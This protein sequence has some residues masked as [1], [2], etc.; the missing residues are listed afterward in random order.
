MKSDNRRKVQKPKDNCHNMITLGAKNHCAVE[1][2]S[3]NSNL[4]G[5][6]DF[7]IAAIMARGG[8]SREPSER[9]ISM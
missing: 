4:K 5:N 3:T 8:S 1:N 2:I 6:S 7:S 9:S